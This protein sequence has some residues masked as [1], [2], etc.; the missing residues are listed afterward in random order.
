MLS[1][2]FTPPARQFQ[3][4]PLNN[5]NY[6]NNNTPKIGSSSNIR[7]LKLPNENPSDV[8][9]GESGIGGQGGPRKDR[10]GHLIKHESG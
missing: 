8:N 2:D 1:V 6:S 9:L 4:S 3:R 7:D 5:N 10:F